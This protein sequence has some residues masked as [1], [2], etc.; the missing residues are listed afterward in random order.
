MLKR[1]ETSI[2]Y[3]TEYSHLLCIIISLV[4]GSKR[5]GWIL[6]KEMIGNCLVPSKLLRLESSIYFKTFF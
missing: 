4:I 6:G 1:K 3:N 2:G 5:R